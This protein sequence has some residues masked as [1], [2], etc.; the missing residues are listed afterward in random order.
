MIKQGNGRGNGVVAESGQHALIERPERVEEL[1]LAG[2]GLRKG[3][4]RKK[5]KKFRKAVKRG[6]KREKDS[7]TYNGILS[8]M[9][10]PA[11]IYVRPGGGGGWYE[12]W[13]R[14]VRVDRVRGEDA[15][16]KRMAELTLEYVQVD[17]ADRT[18]P[19][20]MHAGGGGWYE[21]LAH[22]V[23]VDRVQGEQQAQARADELLGSRTTKS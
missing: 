7:N 15:A 3:D 23:V 13:V 20:A 19:I 21:L 6:R 2:I 18:A 11:P 22:G 1:L 9:R 14:G 8:Q 16:L 17:D 4:S 5:P 12:V 10:A